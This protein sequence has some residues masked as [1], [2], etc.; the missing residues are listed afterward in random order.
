MTNLII[1]KNKNN[2]IYII[3][4]LIKDDNLINMIESKVDF[5]KER[6]DVELK[7]KDKYIVLIQQNEEEVFEIPYLNINYNGIYVENNLK[8]KNVINE[9]NITYFGI[10]V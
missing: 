6:F 2:I 7:N 10:D 8:I 4:K 3:K 1:G 5:K 9:E